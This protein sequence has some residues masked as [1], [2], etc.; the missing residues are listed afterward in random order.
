M[1][2]EAVVKEDFERIRTDVRYEKLFEPN[3]WDVIIRILA[4]PD[5]VELRQTKRKKR[6]TWDTRS[7]RS[8]LPT[9]Y[10]YDSDGASSVRTI[11]QEHE[12]TL[13]VSQHSGYSNYGRSRRTSR[14]SYSSNNVDLRSMTEVTVDFA[15]PETISDGSSFEDDRSLHRSLSHPSLARSASEFTEHWIAPNES[16]VSTPEGS[17]AA[18]RRSHRMMVCNLSLSKPYNI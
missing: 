13:I 5:D 8:S 15:R 4:P 2:T 17:P 3:S 9:L 10:E 14:S 7:R 16:E 11:T 18:V 12:P 1:L 6:E